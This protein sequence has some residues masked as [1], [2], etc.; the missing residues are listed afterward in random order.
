MKI[1]ASGVQKGAAIGL[2]LLFLQT[3][4]AGAAHPGKNQKINVSEITGPLV[5][6]P[7]FEE[8]IWPT[9]ADI[10]GL[11]ESEK[12][13]VKRKIAQDDS[14]KDS[15]AKVRADFAARFNSLKT[16][17]EVEKFIRDYNEKYE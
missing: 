14:S 11:K 10:A 7:E 3:G 15:D 4:Q 8:M 13:S 16:S 9:A 12:N 17:D 6:A 1:S 2:A 5:Q